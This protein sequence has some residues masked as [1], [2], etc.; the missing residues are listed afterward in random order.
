MGILYTLPFKGQNKITSAYGYRTISGKKEWHAGWDVVGV[1]DTD[2]RAACAGDIKSSTII[3]DRSNLTWQWGNY[4]KLRDALKQDLFSCHMA[5][6]AVA[7]GQSVSTGDKLGV[8][9]NTGYSFGAHTHW[10]ARTSA[11]VTICPGELFGLPNVAGVTWDRETMDAAAI[12]YLDCTVAQ[13]RWRV[14]AGTNYALYKPSNVNKSLY[15]RL[16][17]TYRVYAVT[18]LPNGEV[19]CQVTPPASCAAGG[20]PP[21]LWVSAA[22]GTYTAKEPSAQP[23]GESENGGETGHNAVD[24]QSPCNEFIVSA[25]G[26]DRNRL[27]ALCEELQLHV[28]NL[29]VS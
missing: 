12:G 7:V 6:R 25:T 11:G 19:W 26:T 18:A 14:G 21:V 9:G 3:T 2:V 20:S 28:E 16:G 10:E 8:M 13:Y 23:G 5:S 17:V 22:C 15:C 29:R 4:V 1:D 24:W 27:R